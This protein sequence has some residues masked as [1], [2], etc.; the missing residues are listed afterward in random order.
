MRTAERRRDDADG[1]SWTARGPRGWARQGSEGI[2]G[3]PFIDRK[4]GIETTD[5]S[6]LLG[7][8]WLPRLSM[9]MPIEF[10]GNPAEAISSM[11]WMSTTRLGDADAHR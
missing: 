10:P 1:H 6:F 11:S 7:G 5:Y 2:L 9:P 8:L 3:M 4:G